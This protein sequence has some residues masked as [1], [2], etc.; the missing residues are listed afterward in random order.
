MNS[1]VDLAKNLGLAG[2]L[3]VSLFACAMPSEGGGEGEADTSAEEEAAAQTDEAASE[4]RKSGGGTIG[5]GD[6][7]GGTSCSSEDGNQSC[8][9]STGERCVRN[10]T[11]C[12]CEAA[13]RLCGF[14]S[15]GGFILR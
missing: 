8:S 6:S 10:I 5:E 14:G 15:S 12:W 2:F 7:C 13:T 3:G 11:R 9:C 1:L 4:L